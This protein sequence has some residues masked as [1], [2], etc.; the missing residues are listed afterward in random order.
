MGNCI[1]T[2]QC[3]DYK[4]FPRFAQLDITDCGEGTVDNSNGRMYC[5]IHD[6]ICTQPVGNYEDSCFDCTVIECQLNCKCST[7]LHQRAQILDE[8]GK[9]T[10]FY[11]SFIN[12]KLCDGQ[13]ISNVFGDLSC[14]NLEERYCRT[15]PLGTYTTTCKNCFINED[16]CQMSCQCDKVEFGTSISTIELLRCMDEIIYNSDGQ[17]T[18]DNL[19]KQ[20]GCLGAAG[21]YRNSCTSCGLT[22]ARNDCSLTCSCGMASGDSRQSTLSLRKCSSPYVNDVG[23][24]L[25]C[26]L[27]EPANIL[28]DQIASLIGNYERNS[29]LLK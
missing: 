9:I 20:L 24:T 22:Q 19:K 6:A 13:E 14:K 5:D 7:P 4:R 10:H 21:D 1:L 16:I 27:H 15:P 11:N 29:E 3:F 12:L 8:D 26:A 17:L 28:M 2:C 18:C 25:S 23:G